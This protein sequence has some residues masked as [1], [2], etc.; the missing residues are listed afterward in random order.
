MLRFEVQRLAVK[1]LGL[2]HTA[3]DIT[4]QT[5]PVK[6]LGHRFV[7]AQ[8]TV[9]RSASLG[10]FAFI[11]QRGDVRQQ[12]GGIGA[13]RFR[14]LRGAG[15]AG[16]RTPDGRRRHD[17]AHRLRHRQGCRNEYRQRL[18]FRGA[19][20]AEGKGLRDTNRAHAQSPQ[21]AALG[22]TD[23]QHAIDMGQALEHFEHLFLRRQVEVDQQIAAEHEV[24]GR[25][26]GEQGWIEQVADLQAHLIQ[27]PGAKVV[28][29]TLRR[30]I[31]VA[32]RDVLPAKGIL[33]VQRASGL[34]HRERADVH[35]F[36][37]EL[38]RLEPGIQQRHGNRVRFFAG[39]ARQ[40]EYPQGA[41][42]VDLGQPLARQFRQG[43]ERFRVAEKPGFGD[44][45][46]FDQ[47]LLLEA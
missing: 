45:H 32:I 23:K 26:V 11:G 30:E 25:L 14:R 17:V 10:T 46:R 4:Q 18:R 33:A 47:R 3:G 28:A 42:V 35:A 16:E 31:T 24:V 5:E 29:I 20:A 19:L 36:D 40:A 37:L 41:H 44:D 1:P 9:A 12:R 21:Q 43:G 22:R 6:N 15:N 27:H 13:A 34:F 8:V 38:V 7:A 2:Q 39:G